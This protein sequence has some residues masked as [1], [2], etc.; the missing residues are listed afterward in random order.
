MRTA[1]SLMKKNLPAGARCIKL[2]GANHRQFA[3]YGLHFG[4]GEAENLS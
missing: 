4:D 3:H 1:L 2:E